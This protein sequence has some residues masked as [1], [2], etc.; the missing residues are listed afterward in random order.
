MKKYFLILGI[1]GGLFVNNANAVQSDTVVINFTCPDGCML[2]YTSMTGVTAA[3]CITSIGGRPCGDPQIDIVENAVS[4]AIHGV[5]PTTDSNE[6]NKVSAKKKAVSSRATET[7]KMV[8]KIVYEQVVE[9]EDFE[10]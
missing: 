10:M 4:P 7:P 9:D 2:S 3:Q 6:I 1:M 5:N 8:K